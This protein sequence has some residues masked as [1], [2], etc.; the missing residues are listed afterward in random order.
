[1]NKKYLYIIIAFLALM[2][3]CLLTY[4]TSEK[5]VFCIFVKP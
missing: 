4:K 1:M 5:V 3:L 2:I